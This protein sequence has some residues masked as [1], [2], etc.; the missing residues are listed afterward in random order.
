MIEPQRAAALDMCRNSYIPPKPEIL[1][2][3][4]EMMAS[5]DIDLMELADLV[6]Q[7]VGLS[8]AVLKNVNS[9]FFGMRRHVADIRQ[10]VV[11]LGAD[12][13]GQLV[14][15][16]E[17]KRALSGESCLTL[18]RFWDSAAD[19]AE[20]C[21]WIG[22]GCDIGVPIEDLYAVGLFHDCGIPL[23]ATCFADYEATLVEANNDV[24]L[25]MT[26]TEDTRHQVN[27]A[28][29]GYVLLESWDLPKDLCNVILQH[30]EDDIWH[31]LD[32]I[33][34]LQALAV[35]K[36]AENVVDRLRRGTENQDWFRNSAHAMKV[37]SLD[38]ES[39]ERLQLHVIEQM[40]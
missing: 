10:A 11:L 19:V 12:K 28:L 27:H 23:M 4:H 34:V 29:V 26:A 13:I 20:A 18:E 5:E 21:A 38:G 33:L 31:Q 17:L 39:C 8:A 9:A 37:L 35:L 7:D 40:Q 15:G 16:Y 3:L 1:I 36:L 14:S 25:P 2:R 32:N 24:H 6:S 30:H 22:R